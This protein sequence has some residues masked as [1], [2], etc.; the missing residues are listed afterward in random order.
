MAASGMQHSARLSARPSAYSVLRDALTV[1]VLAAALSLV[2]NAVRTD[3]LP[4][5]AEEDFE[6]LVPCPDATGEATAIDPDHALIRNPT[7]LLIDARSR[8]DH[9]A[10]H[11]PRSLSQPFDWLAE[12]D[13]INQEAA[14]IAKAVTRSGKHNVVVYGDGGNPDSGQ[15]WA[16]LLSASGVKNVVFVSGGARALRPLA[17]GIGG[18]K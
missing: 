16:A 5:V 13:E 12:Q 1:L 18:K 3:G 4:L 17:P 8:E 9:G 15:Y 14:Q 6:I 2:V 7:T 10:W 11:L